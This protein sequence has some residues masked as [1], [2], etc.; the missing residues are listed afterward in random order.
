MLE[1]RTSAVLSLRVGSLLRS[2]TRAAEPRKRA[3]KLI[4]S[5]RSLMAPPL[6]RETPKESLLTGKSFPTIRGVNSASV[7]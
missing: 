1:N 6:V 2:R 4:E 3:A 5:G 7:L